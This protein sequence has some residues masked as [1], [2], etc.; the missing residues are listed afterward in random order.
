MFTIIQSHRTERLVSHLL[1]AYQSKQHAIFDEFIVIVPSMVLGDWLDKTIASRA[2]ISTLVT[3]KFWG[4]YQ[5]TLMQ[6]VL[7]KHN[8]WLAEGNPNTPLLNVPEVAVLSTT[9]MQWRLF[10]YLTYYRQSIM[11]D[12]SHPVHPLLESLLGDDS[13]PVQQ[14]TRLWQLATDLARV[15]NRYLT[16]RDNWLNSWSNNEGLDVEAMI[17]EKDEL[18]ERFDQHASQTPPWLTAH[19]CELEVAQRHLWHHLFAGVH[20]HRV[21]IEELFW[22]ALED[23][24]ANERQ[25]LPKALRIFTIQQLPQNELDFL[26]RLSRYTNITLLH[27]NPSKLFW[28]DIVDKV[29]L[30]RQKI[31]NPKSVFLRDH[32][33]AL[34]SRLGKQ[35]RETFA[36]LAGLSGN[37]FHDDIVIDW[38]DRFTEE[39]DPDYESEYKQASLAYSAT[40]SSGAWAD[41][42]PHDSL[43]ARLQ[44]DVLM[45][46]EAAT[47][48][49][50]V[51]RVSQALGEQLQMDFAELDAEPDDWHSDATLQQKRFVKHREWN[52]SEQDNSLSIHACHSLQRQ[53]EILRGM[54]G[55]WLNERN[56]DGSRRHVSDIVVLLPDVDRHHALINSVFVDGKGQ[57]GLTLP[58]KVTGVVDTS[59]RQLWEAVSG[60]YRLLGSE[61]ARFEA[62]EVLDWLMLPPLY[63]SFGLTHEQ[64]SR[65]CDLLIQAGFVR[66]FDEQHL[67][68][69]LDTHDYD[70]RFSF[71]HALDKLT[72]GLIMPEAKVNAS[73]YPLQW[74]DNVLPEKT[75]PLA[76]ISL[77]DAPLIEALCRIYQGL[78][79]RR[80]DH[81][82]RLQAEEWL[83]QIESQVIHTY[84]AAVD[85]T[86][87]MRAIYQAMN[88]FKSSLRANR[89]Y[90]HY[91]NTDGAND[92]ANNL[93]QRLSNVEKLPLKLS[94]MLDSIED[95]LESQQV[96]AEPTGVIT[97]GRFG[98]LRNVPFGLVV[99]LNMNISEFP[100]RDRDNRYD[101]MKAGI[102]QRGDRF[103]EDDDNGAF[104]DALL[105]ARSACWIFYNGQ[106]LTD[107]HEHL[108]A[109]PVSELLQFLQG[110][111]KWQ[112]QPLDSVGAGGGISS[113]TDSATTEQIQRYL[114]KLVERWLVTHHPA[115]PFARDLFEV[116]SA[117]FNDSHVLN[118]GKRLNACSA[119]NAS[120]PLS[121]GQGADIDATVGNNETSHKNQ[122]SNKATEDDSWRQLLDTA[123]QRTKLEQRRQYPPAK[124]WQSVFNELNKRKINNNGRGK[125]YDEYDDVTVRTSAPSI[126]RTVTLPTPPQYRALA[127]LLGNNSSYSQA[128]ELTNKE[129]AEIVKLVSVDNHHLTEA[130]LAKALRQSIFAIE[131]IDIQSLLWQV[132]HPAKQFL[133]EQQVLITQTE[134]SLSRQE[135][136]SLDSLT[137]YQIDDELLKHLHANHTSDPDSHESSSTSSATSHSAD[138]NLQV[139]VYDKMIP[140]GVARQTTLSHQLAKLQRQCDDFKA[141]LQKLDIDIDSPDFPAAG[142]SLLTP[143]QEVTTK[144]NLTQVYAA[145]SKD[146]QAESS[147]EATESKAIGLE[148]IKEWLPNEL[149]LKG[150][151]PCA[152]ATEYKVWLNILPN[153][154]SPKH[155][156]RFW[157]A[158][159]YW[160]VARHTTPAQV[161]TDNGR[162][163]WR[164]NSSSS[165]V[166]AYK[167]IV[168]F[169]LKPIIY[170]QAVM[171]LIKWAIFANLAGQV[172]M[173]LLPSYALIYL[174]KVKE[175]ATPDKKTG[176]VKVYYPKRSDFSDWLA[177]G[178]HA[179]TVYDTCSQHAIWQYVLLG[180]GD[181]FS[182]LSTSLTTLAVPMYQPMF[183]ALV[184]I[185]E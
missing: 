148:V 24:Q 49:A 6:D 69:S 87:S 48:Q 52:V 74:P 107:T 138:D 158:H 73:L 18:S 77:D 123:M 94:F 41:D 65:G 109:N 40:D 68:Q 21:A 78:V 20:Q 136:L 165:Q 125:S 76:G 106:S 163:I 39:D 86:R 17:K 174:D 43:L 84:F 29:W 82:Q 150:A 38:Q 11:E 176:E 47:Q 169:E 85:Q 142:E 122:V 168:T 149:S 7:S 95:E 42:Y 117:L 129:L 121:I 161:A 10:G 90:R 171:Q 152:E 8:A 19:Y 16:H 118:N 141:Q 102:A 60:F 127:K 185:K 166:K 154:A 124:V 1:K 34:L 91:S 71:A 80:D 153:S 172:P 184:P 63:E 4:Q 31:I 178:F 51:G 89:H 2:G 111:V 133:R 50:T 14:E 113:E 110:E 12:E 145:L 167:D 183:E 81:K 46:D 137:R 45:L 15:F 105:C 157:L 115:L 147:T 26:Q 116:D 181:V 175:A 13:D 25:A 179:D 144:V 67:Q 128:A 100:N 44:N 108:P 159:L 61:S 98:A 104:L 96:S 156:L 160:Q 62:P 130:E 28:A 66:G 162:S 22:Q 151:V 3:T 155:L 59:I 119:T 180:Q 114:P 75:L 33:H 101:L 83:K 131:Q 56:P 57:D 126:E 140:A 37:E 182:A 23:N 72:L 55:R 32:G 99:M 112:W 53:L 5:W 35:S 120:E 58:A 54:I 170:E 139:L 70:Y 164:F 88:G 103:S 97:F 132:R 79:A 135:P 64:M 143:T 9:V 173:T 92:E 27:Y 30:Q 93:E 134:A 146:A 36:M 177:P